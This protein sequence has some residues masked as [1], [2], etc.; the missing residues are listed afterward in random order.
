MCFHGNCDIRTDQ[1]N[2]ILRYAASATRTAQKQIA[3]YKLGSVFIT[4]ITIILFVRTYVPISMG[5]HNKTKLGVCT[6]SSDL[7]MDDLIWI[8]FPLLYFERRFIIAK[9]IVFARCAV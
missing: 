4:P 6:G 1:G 9:L 5:T 2:Y 3:Y 7:M 8:T